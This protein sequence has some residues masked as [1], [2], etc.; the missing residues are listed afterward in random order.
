MSSFAVPLRD[1]VILVSVVSSPQGPTPPPHHHHDSFRSVPT[2]AHP[3][4]NTP[5]ATSSSFASMNS[6]QAGHGSGPLYATFH[7]S[8]QSSA[9]SPYSASSLSSLPELTSIPR[10]SFESFQSGERLDPLAN[11]GAAL[12]P[13]PG[14]PQSVG[15]QGY[16]RRPSESGTFLDN[17]F[18]AQVDLDTWR[19]YTSYARGT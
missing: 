9:S 11:L 17:P 3:P 13:Q 14:V 16:D 15:P 8:S 19:G 18:A 5:S 7:Y 12:A 1:L 4:A 6:Q 2:L 10:R